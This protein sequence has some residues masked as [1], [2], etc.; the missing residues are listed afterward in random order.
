MVILAFSIL[1]QKYCFWANLVEQIKIEKVMI[2]F[3]ILDQKYC[4]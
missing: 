1:D 2:A 3:S 4:F